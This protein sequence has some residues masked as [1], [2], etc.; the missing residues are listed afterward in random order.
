[1]ITSNQKNYVFKIVKNKQLPYSVPSQVPD[2]RD[3]A[4]TLNTKDVI[5]RCLFRSTAYL[6]GAVI[7]GYGA[8]VEL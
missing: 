3:E 6:K 7:E 8:I 4:R 2:R 5:M 1:M